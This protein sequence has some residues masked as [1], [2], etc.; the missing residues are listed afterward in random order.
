MKVFQLI[1]TGALATALLSSCNSN[2]NTDEEKS[3]ETS[4][5]KTETKKE[6]KEYQ[7]PDR[8]LRIAYINID[9]V[10]SQYKYM[11]D[12]EAKLTEE[13]EAMQANFDTKLKSFERW[14]AKVQEEFPLMLKS[15]QQKAQEE[16]MKKQQELQQMQQTMQMQLQQK[17]MDFNQRNLAK[18]QGFCK[19]YAEENGFDFVITAGMGSP[20]LYANA[21]FDV[22]EAVIAELNADYDSTKVIINGE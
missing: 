7:G 4:E 17:E 11:K 5:T 18:L 10:Q 1:L 15:E 22:T 13:A 8:P 9:S 6:V 19:S 2:N 16:M 12:I 20:I 14:Q 3:N 21:D